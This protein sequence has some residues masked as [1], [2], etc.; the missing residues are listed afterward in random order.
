MNHPQ[1]CQSRGLPQHRYTPAKMAYKLDLNPLPCP[2]GQFKHA[3][4]CK[5]CPSGTMRVPVLG[6]DTGYC[7]F[8]K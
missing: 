5:S 6:A 3:G 7:A 8:I 2:S 4:M 1:A